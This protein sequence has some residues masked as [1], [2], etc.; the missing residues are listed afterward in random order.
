MVLGDRFVHS[1]LV[2][3]CWFEPLGNVLS[4][5][6]IV[7]CIDFI[8]LSP[9]LGVNN[10]VKTRRTGS[11]FFELVRVVNLESLLRAISGD[12]A[13]DVFGAFAPP[14]WWRFL[15]NVDIFGVDLVTLM[16]LV[17]GSLF[18]LQLAVRYCD[19][20]MLMWARHRIHV[21]RHSLPAGASWMLFTRALVCTAGWP[22]PWL[23]HLNSIVM[24]S[25]VMMMALIL[26][27][28]ARMQLFLSWQRFKSKTFCSSRTIQLVVLILLSLNCRCSLLLSVLGWL[29][30]LWCEVLI[31]SWVLNARCWRWAMS[32]SL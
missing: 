26:L 28:E 23:L 24:V 30:L 16:S 4:V 13:G 7:S 25:R 2:S 21:Q 31:W 8:V 6:S 10:R 15:D 9:P 17:V 11:L 14:R 1:S 12:S 18:V 5:S 20:S 22:L 3:V 27:F 19:L 29:I 32:W